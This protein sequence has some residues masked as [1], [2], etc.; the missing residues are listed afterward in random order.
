MNRYRVYSTGTGVA[1][2]DYK[3]GTIN[4]VYSCKTRQPKLAD[5]I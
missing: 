2:I 1:R 4:K 3:V 5:L